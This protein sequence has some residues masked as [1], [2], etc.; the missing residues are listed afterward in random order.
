[1]SKS[2]EL[3]FLD[4]EGKT[5]TLTIRE[6][7]ANLDEAA[8]RQVMDDIVAQQLF[9]NEGNQ[10][11]VQVKSARYVERLVTDVFDDTRA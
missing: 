1:M 6:P 10:L 11:Y 5:K 7:E 2:L 8:I 9:E 4:T 3:K